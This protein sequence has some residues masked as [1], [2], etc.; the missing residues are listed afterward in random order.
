VSILASVVALALTIAF[1]TTAI[2][3]VRLTSLQSRTA[4]RLEVSLARW[5]VI[6]WMEGVGALFIALGYRAS[7][8]SV[9][10]VIN[11]IGA[12]LMLLVSLYVWFRHRRAKDSLAQW[13]GVLVLALASGVELLAR[14]W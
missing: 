3:R 12:G 10:G 4:E 8:G 7:R 2:Q 9:L 13:G 5:R 14:L 6:G 1:A 11:E